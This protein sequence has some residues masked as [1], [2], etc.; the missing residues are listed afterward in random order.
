MLWGHGIFAELI[1]LLPDVID[2]RTMFIFFI[3]FFLLVLFLP[4]LPLFLKVVGGVANLGTLW[5]Y[6]RRLNDLGLDAIGWYWFDLDLLLI[7]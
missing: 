1:L 3:L 6:P 5:S 4:F 2:H 7:V